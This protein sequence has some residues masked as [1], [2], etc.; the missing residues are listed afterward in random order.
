MLCL[1][2]INMAPFGLKMFKRSK[3]VFVKKFLQKS[4][5]QKKKLKIILNYV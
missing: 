4:I 5:C 3:Q 1:T 2:I